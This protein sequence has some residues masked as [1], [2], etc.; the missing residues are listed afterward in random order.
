M[1]PC[2]WMD[3]NAPLIVGVV[4]GW[5]GGGVVVVVVRDENE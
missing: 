2:L 5:G 4:G 1:H 3:T